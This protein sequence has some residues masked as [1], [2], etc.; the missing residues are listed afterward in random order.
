MGIFKNIIKTKKF[1]AICG[2][3]ASITAAVVGVAIYKNRENTYR[4]IKVF[5]VEGS[6]KVARNKSDELN[7]YANMVLISGDRVSLEKGNLTLSADEDKYIYMEEQTELVLNATGNSENSRTK[8]DLIRGAITNELQH[9]L[10]ARMP[11]ASGFSSGELAIL[12]H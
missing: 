6:A 1:M 7:P 8:I 5:E 4:I 11:H 9:K 2:V 3:A 10:T 12:Q